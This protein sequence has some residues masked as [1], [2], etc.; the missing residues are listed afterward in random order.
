MELYDLQ[1]GSNEIYMSRRQQISIMQ[2]AEIALLSITCVE[3]RIS[4]NSQQLNER[5]V[6]IQNR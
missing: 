1:T 6:Y 4:D 5:K 2:K 3:S